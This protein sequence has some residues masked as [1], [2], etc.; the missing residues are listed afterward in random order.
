MPEPA[1]VAIAGKYARQIRTGALPPGTQL[2]SYA[3]IAERNGVSQIVVRHAVK[4]LL[5]QG[6]VRSVERRGTFVADRIDL[7]RLAPERQMESPETSFGQETDREVKVE[8]TSKRLSATETLAEILGVHL[9]EEITQITTRASED[10][11][12]IS[13][14]DAYQPLDTEGTEG[15]AFLEETIADQLPAQTHAAW[16]NTPDGALVKHVRQRF[17]ARDDRVLMACDISFPLDRYS[18]FV[19]R[20]SLDPDPEPADPQPTTEP[21][22][23][24]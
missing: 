8:R 1:Y 22:P 7:V 6:L 21:V 20:M 19:F 18:A 10:G 11:R 5:S 12:P 9:G 16:L 17:L 15:A 4:L 23:T 24:A 14:S 13:I 3:E 2:P